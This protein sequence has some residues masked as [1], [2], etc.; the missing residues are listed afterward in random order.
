MS[1]SEQGNTRSLN[2]HASDEKQLL[3]LCTGII[4]EKIK[5]YLGEVLTVPSWVMMPG[6]PL[7]DEGPVLQEMQ[8]GPHAATECAELVRQHWAAAPLC[9]LTDSAAGRGG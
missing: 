1:L 7:L 4:L 8:S 2:K 6:P 9:C 5:A 3:F